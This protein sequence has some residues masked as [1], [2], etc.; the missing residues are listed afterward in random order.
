[1]ATLSQP[2]R[3]Q[4]AGLFLVLLLAGLLLASAAA[5][6]SPQP[7][8]KTD[9]S[10]DSGAH[11]S[12]INGS[13]TRAGDWPWQ[14]AL[15]LGG[16]RTEDISA[17]R[18]AFCG[19]S[20]IA[21][22]L[23]ITAA[24]CVADLEPSLLRQ[25][26]VIGGR[27]WLSNDGGTSSYVSKRIL[28]FSPGGLPLFLDNGRTA[29][30][31]VALLKLK[32]DLPGPPIKLAGVGESA[33]FAPGMTVKT[34]G[35]GV[36]APL[37]PTSSNVLRLITQV[38]LSDAVCRRENGRFYSPRTMICLGGPAGRTSTCFGDSG[39]PMVARLSSGWRLVGLTSFGDYFCDPSVPSVD[40]RVSGRAVRAWVRRISLR[41]SDVDPIGSGGVP[42][43]VTTWCTVPDLIG[44]TVVQS[45]AALNRAGCRL[46]E[47]RR[48]SLGFGQLGRVNE[49]SLPQ[50][51][52]SPIGQSIDVW[53][54]R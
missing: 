39:G 8:I 4:T 19:G 35:W 32:R 43:P 12:M 16:P 31:D 13:P 6:A 29:W 34:T 9:T 25:L 24:H 45:R 5:N 7:G 3:F 20:L 50:G 38:V 30:W 36:T 41:E 46:G 42:R 37:N 49:S 44:R 14:V 22:D 53:V 17:R 33:S 47:V 1:M 15:A 23:V 28:P 54:N 51:W 18:R 26:E 40:T 48:E 52:L 27:T 10:T 2:N 11:T 21:A